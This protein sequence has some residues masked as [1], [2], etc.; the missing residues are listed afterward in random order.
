[1]F[2]PYKVATWDDVPAD[3]KDADGKWINDYGGYMSDRLRL[4]QGAGA[5][6]R[7]ATC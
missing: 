5:H 4:G 2:A 7:Q 6:E 1:M 3:F